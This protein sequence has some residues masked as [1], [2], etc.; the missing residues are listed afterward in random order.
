MI[1]GMRKFTLSLIALAFSTL[2]SLCINSAQ[3]FRFDTWTTDNGLPQVSI[4]TILQTRDGFLW[5]TTYGGL[6][7]YDGSRFEVFNT[8]NTDG[9]RTSRFTSLLEDKQGTLWIGTEG[10]GLTRYQNGVFTTLTKDNGLPDNSID[11]ISENPSGTLI[12][13]VRGQLFQLADDARTSDRLCKPTGILQRT[14]TGAIWYMEGLHLRKFENGKVA[15]D[16]DAGFPILRSFEDSQGRVWIA[17]D[18][19]DLLLMLQDGR[20]TTFTKKDGY[21]NFRYGS[22]SEDRQG[23]IWFGTGDGLVVFNNGRLNR[24]SIAD[25]LVR[26]GITYVYQDREGTIWAGSTGGLSRLTRRAVTTYSVAD[27]L[28]AE[29]IYP[30]Y[31]DMGGRVWIGSWLGL[32]VYENGKFRNVGADYGVADALVSALFVD[33]DDSLWIGTW[34]GSVRHVVGGK[35]AL[36]VSN[37]QLGVRTRAI[38]QDRTGNIWIGGSN[39][40]TRYREG[41]FTTFDSSNGLSGNEVFVIKEDHLG[42]LWIGTESGLTKFKDGH[43]TALTEKDGV[44]GN[45]VRAIMEDDEG[46]LWVGT[47]DHGLYRLKQGQAIH[48]TTNEGLFDN[49]VFQIVADDLGS[50]WMSCNLGIYRVRKSDLTDFA[51][52]R[53]RKIT[54]IPY[55]KRDGM[56][57]SECNGGGQS[58]GLKTRTGEIWFPTQQGVAVI[59]PKAVPFNSNAPPTVIE[60][61]IVDA[62]PVAAVS[63]VT[64]QPGQVYFEIHYSGLSFINPELVRFKYR[65]EGLDTDWVD[66]NV[67]RTAYY[68]HVPP[69]K[70]TFTVRAANRDGVWDEQGATI[71]IT[72]LPPFW[73][74]RWFVM[75]VAVVLSGIGFTL[76]WRRI[77]RLKRA[78]AMHEAFSEQLIQSQETERRRIAIELHDS[79]GQSLVLIRNWALLGL[80]VTG[81]KEPARAKLDE[82][83]T[84]ASE[85]I[86]EVRE[87]AYNLGPYQLDSLGLGA[88]IEEMVQRVA[89]SSPTRFTVEIDK[90]DTVFSKQ[91]EINIYRIVQEAVNNIIKHSEAENASVMI[92]LESENVKVM[93]RDDGIGFNRRSDHPSGFEQRGFGLLGLA[94]RVRMLKGVWVV[95]SEPGKGS[96]INIDLPRGRELN[97]H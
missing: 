11:E 6:V 90:L 80:K 97:G 46:A 1:E 73:R 8:G 16:F 30:L 24:Y 2:V 47:Y 17:R 65:L 85:A 81:E 10:Q 33:R 92:R 32:T 42:Q 57:N 44:G 68:S 35:T 43:F 64:I 75:V 67:R 4:N 28:A 76:Y 41:A 54:S 7:R 49:G 14:R 70:Y 29:N 61:L 36:V 82:I 40:L 93:I 71:V 91:D 66:A 21:S 22:A 5:L 59:D 38:F 56:L 12:L 39:G 60:S 69:G 37:G 87:I 88:S 18:G 31:E 19:K 53:I 15:V 9:L 62:T 52:G 3:Q 72:V 55:N 13:K 27:G 23:R 83:S 79:L 20:L 25:G 34:G 51:A 74:T 89:R 78:S 45:I 63:P 84:T 26:G 48:Y 95:Q 94:E 77:S 86:N 58:A 50:F 96:T